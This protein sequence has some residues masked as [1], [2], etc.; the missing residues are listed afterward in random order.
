MTVQKIG[1]EIEEKLLTTAT[2]TGRV[3]PPPRSPPV[4][5]ANQQQR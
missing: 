2:C 4:F 5:L 1:K 3:G